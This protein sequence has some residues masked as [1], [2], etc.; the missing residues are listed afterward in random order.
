MNED[1]ETTQHFTHLD[2]SFASNDREMVAQLNARE[3]DGRTLKIGSQSV[4]PIIRGSVGPF[5]RESSHMD[6]Y[7][8]YNCQIPLHPKNEVILAF[9]G[10][11]S[12]GLRQGSRRR[13]ETS[14]NGEQLNDPQHGHNN[15]RLTNERLTD[16]RLTFVHTAKR[17]R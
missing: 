14:A 9:K 2:Y 7:Y 16:R 10:A 17:V 13:H 12:M 11:G 8:Y 15:G 3:G 5:L 1:R 4:G 6:V